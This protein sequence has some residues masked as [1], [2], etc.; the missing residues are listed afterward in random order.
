[1]RSYPSPVKLKIY[2]S[3]CNNYEKEFK[4]L[5]SRAGGE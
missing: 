3:T 2:I 5:A 1:L 4:T